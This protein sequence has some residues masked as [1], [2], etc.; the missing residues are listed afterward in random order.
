LVY[1][2]FKFDFTINYFNFCFLFKS[3]LTFNAISLSLSLHFHSLLSHSSTTHSHSLLSCRS[4]SKKFRLTL[5]SLS[6]TTHP[7][8][9]GRTPP[10]GEIGQLTLTG[11]RS[12]STIGTLS[13]YLTLS[14]VLISLSLSLSYPLM[15]R[16]CRDRRI[17]LILNLILGFCCFGL[18]AG[19]EFSNWA[20]FDDWVFVVLVFWI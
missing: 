11:L 10:P 18:M 20:L 9:P 1:W 5:F 15:F 2:N 14:L 19:F 16:W 3:Y 12:P 6:S 7:Y 4:L 8:R 17:G 13:I